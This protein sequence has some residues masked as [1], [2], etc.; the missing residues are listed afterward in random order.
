LIIKAVDGRTFIRRLGEQ[1]LLARRSPSTASTDD[2]W[3]DRIM[4]LRLAGEEQ[5]RVVSRAAAL[6]IVGADAVD[7]RCRSGRWSR[8]APAVYLMTPPVAPWDRLHVAFL[9]AGPA[10]VISGSAALFAR[11]LRAARAPATVLTLVPL[12]AGAANWGTIR[13]RRTARLPEARWRMGVPLA[14]VAR[15]VADYALDP[16]QADRVQA[17]VARRYSV[18]YAR[19]RTWRRNWNRDPP[20]QPT[21]P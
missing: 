11:D 5:P 4:P 3:L 9:H 1:L 17:V 8:L 7:Y 16:R 6:R 10:S 18:S 2:E 21:V 13:V 12:R 15:A 20:G 14:P 19:P